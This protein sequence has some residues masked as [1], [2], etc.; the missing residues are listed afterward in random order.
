MHT[1]KERQERVDR[2]DPERRRNLRARW[3]PLRGDFA[4]GAV[5]TG[6]SFGGE[7]SRSRLPIL[8]SSWLPTR[9]A[10]V[11]GAVLNADGGWLAA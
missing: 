10:F 6:M 9:Q 3:N 11:N 7:P 8:L 4:P 2:V 1:T 5:N